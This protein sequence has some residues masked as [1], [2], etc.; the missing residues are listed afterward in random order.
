MIT[1][2]T[3]VNT[4]LEKAWEL[5]TDASHVTKWNSASEDWHTP[6]AENDFTEGGKFNYR[7]EAKDGSFGFDFEGT[8][9]SISQGEHFA[10]TLGDG[11]KVD[12]HFEAADDKTLVT[13]AFEPES[14]NPEEMQEEGWQSILDNFKKYAENN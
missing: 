13:V 1:I 5:Y 14:Q 3:A 9:N 11:R 12:V 10:Y 4:P 8:Y 2:Q 7:M 6:T